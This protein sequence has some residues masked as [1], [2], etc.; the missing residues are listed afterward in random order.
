MLLH[1]V[2]M[3]A[4]IQ[5]RQSAVE[6]PRER[7]AAVLVFLQ[8]LEF[9]DQVDFELRA[10]PHAELKGDVLVGVSAAVAPSGG[11]QANSLRFLH[12]LLD[13]QLVAVE[14]GLTFNY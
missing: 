1:R 9:P 14:P 11:F 10:D 6:I 8:A 12:P 4:L 7:E 3:D 5:L 2:G 13:A